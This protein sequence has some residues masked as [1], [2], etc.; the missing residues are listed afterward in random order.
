MQTDPGAVALA[1][2]A[3]VCTDRTVWARW[4]ELRDGRAGPRNRNDSRAQSI[5]SRAVFR[6]IPTR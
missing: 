4:P 1:R 3:A 6:A 2:V 5:L